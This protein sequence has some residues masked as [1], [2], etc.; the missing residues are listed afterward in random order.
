M[1]SMAI[2]EKSKCGILPFGRLRVGMT[3]VFGFVVENKQRQRQQQRQQATATAA[4]KATATAKATADSFAAL[5]NDKEKSY[6]M[7]REKLWDDK[8]RSCGMARELVVIRRGVWRCSR[9]G[10]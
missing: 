7:T 8:G 4:I 10:L 3:S 6:G 5:R 2:Q 9:R 1:H